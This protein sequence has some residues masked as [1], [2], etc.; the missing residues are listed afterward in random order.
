[1]HIAVCR[2]FVD[3]TEHE[4]GICWMQWH[5]IEVSYCAPRA[6]PAWSTHRGAV[7]SAHFESHFRV[8]K[9]TSAAQSKSVFKLWSVR[10]SRTVSNKNLPYESNQLSTSYFRHELNLHCSQTMDENQFQCGLHPAVRS[11]MYAQISTCK[12]RKSSSCASESEFP[13]F[14][15]LRIENI[16]RLELIVIYLFHFF[17]R[18]RWLQFKSG[19]IHHQA[20]LVWLGFSGRP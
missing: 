9:I 11:F 1:M 4:R 14:Q 10:Y 8:E 19:R 12:S 13:I 3:V 15:S 18:R 5:V 2:A 17:S 20:H 16:Q 7:C 6:N